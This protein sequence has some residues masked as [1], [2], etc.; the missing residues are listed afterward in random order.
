MIIKAKS[1]QLLK[2]HM[3]DIIKRLVLQNAFVRHVAIQL[4]YGLIWTEP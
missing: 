3:D 1:L 2:G 4:F